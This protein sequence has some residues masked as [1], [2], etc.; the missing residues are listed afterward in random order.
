MVFDLASLSI[1]GVG[2][3]RSVSGWLENAFEDGK[4][5]SYEWAQLGSTIIRTAL[6]SLGLMFG[7]DLEPIAASG[8]AFVLDFLASKL[9]RK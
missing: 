6:L 4:I 5:S 7:F 8:S 3:V 1:I 2:L 9:S